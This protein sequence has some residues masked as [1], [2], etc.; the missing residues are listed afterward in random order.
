MEHVGRGHVLVRR[1]REPALPAGDAELETCAPCHA[2]R[3]TI[4]EG[5]MAGQPLLDTHRP[6]LLDTGLY[7]ADGQ[8]SEEVYEYG[9]FIQSPMYAAGV[10]CGDCHDPHSLALR[11][12]GN[13]VCAQCHQPEVFD[14]PEHH[15]HAAGSAGAKCAACH[16]PARTYMQIDV[17]RDHSFRVPRPDLSVA[18]GTPNACTDCHAGKSARRCARPGTNARRRSP[19]CRAQR[20]PR[21][22]RSCARRSRTASRSCGSA[23][24]TR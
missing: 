4:A 11:A 20:V 6:A 9:S 21:R 1:E 18:I 13:A 8:M 17:R 2:R 7:E 5:R 16:M 3:S 14:R 10:R 23:R 15:R 12:E 22:S 19:S 24:S